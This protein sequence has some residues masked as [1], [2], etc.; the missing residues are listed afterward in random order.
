M[1]TLILHYS[2]TGHTSKAAEAVAG[3]LRKAGQDVTLKLVET[4]KAKMFYLSAGAA[5]SRQ[6]DLDVTTPGVDLAPYDRVVVGAPVWSWKG[7]PI[8]KTY[9]PACKGLKGKTI[10]ALWSCTSN[11]GSSQ[12]ILTE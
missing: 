4:K 8:W 1:K 2:R 11:P 3:A 10:H 9:L 6:K 7:C 5:G 12:E